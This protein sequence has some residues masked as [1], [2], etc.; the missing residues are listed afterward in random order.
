MS[1]SMGANEP[2]TPSSLGAEFTAA[3]TPAA[4]PAPSAAAA[5]VSKP[6]N[7]WMNV[8][9]WRDPVSS[10][11]VFTL[12][13]AAYYCASWA[14]SGDTSI[15]PTSAVAYL[16]LAHLGVNFVRFFCSARWHAAC[17]WEESAWMDAAT[18]RAVRVVRRTAALHDAY[19]SSRDPHVTLGVSAISHPSMGQRC[20]L[21]LIAA[22]LLCA[23][24]TRPACVH[25]PTLQTRWLL[26]FGR[27]HGWAPPSGERE[28]HPMLGRTLNGTAATHADACLT[29][30]PTHPIA[31]LLHPTLANTAVLTSSWLLPTWAPS[32]FPLSTWLIAPLLM[33]TCPPSTVPHWGA[34]TTWRCHAQPDCWHCWSAWLRCSS[35]QPGRSW[36]LVCWWP[37]PTG[38]PHC[39]LQ[40]WML[41]ALPLSP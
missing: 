37:L 22:P 1:T 25:Y 5:A 12:G 26:A 8:F 24:L 40:R 13:V 18:E 10:V 36:P 27:W 4:T 38:A 2:A 15:T 6:A 33:P 35:S 7:S 34:S 31:T 30:H 23:S 39:S 19:L 20:M 11:L 29:A 14:L 41:S 16:L 3:A 9:L 28:K 17:M 21:R 32:L